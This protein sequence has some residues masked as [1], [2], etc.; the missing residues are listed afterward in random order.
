[1]WVCFFCCLC[2]GHFV[3]LQRQDEF[4]AISAGQRPEEFIL[5]GG[6]SWAKQEFSS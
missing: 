1:M 2:L 5:P 4:L 3:L 6:D